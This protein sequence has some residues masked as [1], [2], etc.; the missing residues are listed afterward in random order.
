MLKARTDRSPNPSVE[1]DSSGQ[2]S[3]TLPGDRNGHRQLPRVCHKDA[4][5]RRSFGSSE[6]SAKNPAVCNAAEMLVDRQCRAVLWKRVRRI[7]R[8]GRTGD[9]RGANPP[10]D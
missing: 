6:R 1:P 4:T 10:P 9:A 8:P 7:V 5:R 3:T 2:S